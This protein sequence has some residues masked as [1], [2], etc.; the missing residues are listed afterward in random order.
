MAQNDPPFV[1]PIINEGNTRTMRNITALLA[2]AAAIGFMSETCDVVLVKGQDGNPLRVNKD[3]FD[4]DQEKPVKDR[5]Y[6]A[7]D[8]DDADEILNQSVSGQQTFESLGIEPQAAPSAPNFNGGTNTNPLPVDPA[9]NAAAPATTSPNQRLVMKEGKKF[10]LV[11]ESGIK[12]T[13]ADVGAQ[14]E[15]GGYSTQ[16]AAQEAI[17]NLPR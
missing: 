6:T 7:Y 14:I 13:T 15:E 12:L 16:E 11:N 5:Q 8:G 17:K 9:K 10:F 1:A 2:S 4:A 3:D